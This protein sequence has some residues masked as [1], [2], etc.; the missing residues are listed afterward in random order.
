MGGKAK[1][2]DTEALEQIYSVAVSFKTNNEDIIEQIRFQLNQL[3]DPAFLDGMKGE[4]G[5]E[6]VAAIHDGAAALEELLELID[7]TSD[8][9]EFKIAEAVR[10]D[11]NKHGDQDNQA[12]NKLVTNRLYLKR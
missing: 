7:H 3:T 2:L 1:L 4:R 11:M 10:V 8:F 12:A 5:Q 9:I 6:C